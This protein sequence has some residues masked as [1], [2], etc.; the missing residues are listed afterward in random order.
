MTAHP[1]PPQRHS[2]ITT[3]DLYLPHTNLH[4]LRHKS[5][6]RTIHHTNSS[7]TSKAL[8]DLNR[9]LFSRAPSTSAANHHTISTD[10]Q[11]PPSSHKSQARTLHHTNNSLTSK[12]IMIRENLYHMG[13]LSDAAF[14]GIMFGV[15]PV[16]ALLLIIGV[17]YCILRKGFG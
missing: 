1:L 2:Y 16:A 4:P 5:Q 12:M 10:N 9:S 14:A 8:P 15:V 11:P 7:S 3:H 13:G 6:A 17:I